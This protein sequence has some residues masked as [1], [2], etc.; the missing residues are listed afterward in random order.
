MSLHKIDVLNIGL[1]A[2]DLH[3]VGCSTICESFVALFVLVSSI[4]CLKRC[5]C[6]FR[7]ICGSF[8]LLILCWSLICIL[9]AI[10][11]NL[12]NRYLWWQMRHKNA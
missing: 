2:E 8:Q 10:S 5:G 6:P 4:L 12:V 1:T 7:L 11:R 3:L 9:K